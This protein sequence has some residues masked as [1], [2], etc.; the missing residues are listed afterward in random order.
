MKPV[1][2]LF[3]LMLHHISGF[4]QTPESLWIKNT[5]DSMTLDEKIGQLFIVRAYGNNDTNAITALR[6]TISKYN[7]GGLFFFQGSADIQAKL[8][9]EYQ[10]LSKYPLLISMDAEWGLGMRLK[11]DGFS[12]PK[13]LTLGA[14]QNNHL[15]YDT[16][17]N[18]ASHLKRMGVH[19]NFAPVLDINNNPSNPVIN[20]RSFGENKLNVTSKSYLFMQ[21][22]QDGGVMACAKHFPG[23]GNT[24]VDSHLDL[25]IINSSRKELDSI[26]LYPFQVITKLNIA[27]VMVAHL[28]IPS[29]DSCV[30]MPCSLS[31]YIINSI[32]RKE[33]HYDGLV[34]TDALE[35]KGVTK[36]FTAGELELNA[37][38]AGNDVLLLSEKLPE[39]IKRIKTAILSG[40]ISELELDEKVKR[41]L[42]AKA[43]CGLMNFIPIKL[44]EI[45]KDINKPKSYAL[46]DKLYRNA[47]TLIKD[48][49]NAVPIR[50]I[51]Q[52]IVTISVGVTSRTNFQ[53]RISSYCKTTEF[54]LN[55]EQGLSE[56]MRTQIEKADLVIFSLHKLNYKKSDRYGLSSISKQILEEFGQNK[57]V[58][59][60]VFGSPYVVSDFESLAAIMLAYEDTELVQD[61]AAQLLFGTDPI[62]G[63]LPITISKTLQQGKSIKRP[64]LMRLGYAIPESTQLNS[65][66]LASIRNIVNQIILSKAAPG[67]QVLVAKDNK[68]VFNEAFGTLD[69]QALDSV[70]L[71]TLY[72]IAS[73]TKIMAT[74]P[75][76]MTLEDDGKLDYQKPFANYLPSFKNT[77]KEKLT[78]KDFLLHQGQLVSWIPFYKSTLVA[79]D[80]L[81]IL[82]YEYYKFSK[83]D[84]FGIHVAEQLFLRSDI[85][86]TIKSKI[87]MSKL[88]DQKKYLY[89][90]LGFYFIPELIQ[91]LTGISFVDYL[92]TSIY[93][94]LHIE[95]LTYQPLQHGYQLNDIAPT[96]EDSYFRHQRIQGYVHDMGAAMMNGISGHAGLFSNSQSLA[97]IMQ[98][99]LN[100]GYYGGREYFSSN[101]VRK[102]TGRDAEFSRRGLG[103][104]LKELNTADIPYV[105]SLS[106][107]ATYGHQGFT[108]TCI[109]A[110]P[111]NNILFIF[112]SNRTYPDGKIN[113]LHKY[114]YRT[115]IQDI[116]YKARMVL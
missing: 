105:S 112:L 98:C 21:G 48:D 63:Y 69:Y 83:S 62:R 81:N 26:E 115:Q 45:V 66:T 55:K 67:C 64:S 93:N 44:E 111:V 104:D 50:E 18:M 94:P 4:S 116:I 102:F 49:F 31:P 92:N 87:L 27:S 38:K 84:T 53:K 1:R 41:I 35:M 9:N 74:V 33:Y 114:R 77:N 65:D 20:E 59:I 101:Q 96:E 25:P 40:E 78:I 22:L 107:D 75:A 86:D 56:E 28:S 70:H 5:L 32:L 52:N 82:D 13:Q 88:H 11:S 76:L 37:F 30:N 23:H 19:L 61:I 110:D 73:L 85:I 113:L 2:L 24:D 89:S 14:I 46:K 90:D 47:I 71:N 99:Y 16:G 103:F 43:H 51:P 106:S 108:G 15:I 58:I 57:R 3:F 95:R 97:V 36:N 8:T 54:V 34:I 12:F 10:Q 79:P 109:W 68:I 60:T 17:L 72:D 7:V 80:T 91:S 100:L 6:E 39:A 29:L 42:T